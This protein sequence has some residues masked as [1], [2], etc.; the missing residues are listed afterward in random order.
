MSIL[1]V[2]SNCSA[3]LNAPDSAAGKKVKCPKCQTAMVVPEPL[4]AEEAFEVVAE[5]PAKKPTAKPVVK[6]EVTL[7]D[8][9]D[10]K[11]RKKRVAA[12]YDDDD[13][14]ERPRKKKKAA[15]GDSMMVRNIIGGVVLVILLG[16]AGWVFY[17]KYGKKDEQTA[18]N[19]DATPPAGKRNETP[20]AKPPDKGDVARIREMQLVVIEVNN[21]VNGAVN[22]LNQVTNNDTALAASKHLETASANLRRLHDQIKGFG[23]FGPRE[24]SEVPP[25]SP[26]LVKALDAAMKRVSGLRDRN[27]ISGEAADTLGKG[28]T[29]LS[30]LIGDMAK[31][32]IDT[33][34]QKSNK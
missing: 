24:S 17:D 9:E 27:E 22:A 32:I 18:D 20:L 21:T 29:A 30:Q 8:D 33:W 5:S 25:P 11:P 1:V 23:K 10:A 3:K 2:C 26:G 7:D 12:E 28:L 19:G 31:T 4:P 14:D 13:D 34:P 15:A 16:V 6:A